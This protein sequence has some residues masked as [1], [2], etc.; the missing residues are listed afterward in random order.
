[1]H[2]SET[3][4]VKELIICCHSGVKPKFVFFWGHK[5]PHDS[6]VNQACLSQWYPAPFMVNHI[7][8][9]TAEHYMMAEKARLFRDDEIL[10]RILQTD[11]PGA[12]KALGRQVQ[13]FEPQ[14]WERH[15]FDIVTQG[16]Y[17]KF[18]QN[19]TLQAFLLATQQRVL[20]EASPTDRIWGIGLPAD[21]EAAQL[22]VRWRGLNLLGFAL[23]EARDRLIKH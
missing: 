23:M 14:I 15:R 13:N 22:P 16:N 12:A 3:R 9:P 18:T 1:M 7:I 19:P 6:S 5:P 4:N 8:Y 21:H 2:P 11:N 10:A 17:L 20:V